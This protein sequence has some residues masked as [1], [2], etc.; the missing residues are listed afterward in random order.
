[1]N[2]NRRNFIKK[3]GTIGIAGLLAAAPILTTAEAIP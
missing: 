1:M 3:I 2:N